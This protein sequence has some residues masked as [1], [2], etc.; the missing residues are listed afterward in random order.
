MQLLIPMEGRV[1]TILHSPFLIAHRETETTYSLTG[2]AM[3][4]AGITA[5]QIMILP[6][7]VEVTEG[8]AVTN[9]LRIASL[10]LESFMTVSA[11]DALA[12]TLGLLLRSVVADG[13]VTDA[14]LL[15]VAP[16]LEGR[17]WQPGIAV[18]VGDVY[19]FGQFLWKC[20]QAHTTQ[21]DWPPDL[22]PAL[23]RK[24]EVV[25]EGGARIWEVGVGYVVGDLVGYAETS[26][27]AASEAEQSIEP[28]EFTLFDCLQ[29]HTSQIGWEPPNAPALWCV[30]TT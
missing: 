27:D 30:H 3:R 24:V 22:A 19:T 2:Q 15:R 21:R 7:N 9:A 14:E 28:N 1:R 20:V 11:E 5:E 6:D 12:D 16:A 4:M 29:A 26:D 8:Q 18:A 25:P 13:R 10:P 23:W 17:L